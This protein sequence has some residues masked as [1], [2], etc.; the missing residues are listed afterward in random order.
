VGWGGGGWRGEGGAVSER[1][2]KK[3]KGKEGGEEGEMEGGRGLHLPKDNNTKQHKLSKL[4]STM[5][6]S[7]PAHSFGLNVS[8]KC[9]LNGGVTVKK[10]LREWRFDG[11]RY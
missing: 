10:K 9:G 1:P 7:F 4:T 6:E 5:V 3:N 11:D 2:R 8:R